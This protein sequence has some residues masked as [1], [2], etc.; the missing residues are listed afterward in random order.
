M[1][2]RS[3]LKA[4]VA[5]G[6]LLL[7]APAGA[8]AG[9]L[10]PTAEFSTSR[11][12]RLFP[13][14]RL[15][16]ADMHNH[17][18]LSD[19]NGDAAKAFASMRDA[20]LDVAALTDHAGTSWGAP[21]D[22]CMGQ[23]DCRSV[24]GIDE[25]AWART[26]ELANSA[27]APDAFTAIRGFEWS[28]PFLGHVNVWF[29]ERWIDPLHTGGVGPEGIGEHFHE[30]IPGAGPAVGPHVDAATRA[31]PANSGMALFYDWLNAAPTR[32]GIGGGAD[33]LT[34]FNHP[35]R[36]YG[37]FGY[38]RLDP[39]IRD[40]MVSMEVFNRGEDYLFAQYANGQPS[41][42]AECLDAGWRTGL[43][44]VTDEHGTNWGYP[45]GKGRSG[46]WVNELSRE[47][48]R[49]ALAARRFFATTLRG[50]RVDAGARSGAGAGG[51][52]EARMG[53]TLKHKKG[54]VTFA[55]DVDRGP[56]WWGKPLQVQVLRSGGR[57]PKVAHVED[58]TVRSDSEDV[59]TFTVNLDVADG[60]WVVLRVADPAGSNRE[61]G[62]AGH[63]GNAQ[64]IAYASPFWLQ[65]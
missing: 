63:P 50:L 46:L 54:P 7:G 36:E 43:L 60:S 52:L 29:S 6:A 17:T 15:A 47:G 31:N 62:P 16:H 21:A 40:R 11:A 1:H 23:K 55:L 51:P 2:R 38:F 12:S 59:L 13:G 8:L 30:N 53:S 10:G 48:V 41:P 42:L 61:P 18:L 49:E 33:A 37:R 28:S 27:D 5:G 32:P 39:R 19:G 26:R 9:S 45:D 4:A 65:P 22:P 14:T 25:A 24:A 57:V 56:D 35:G 58:F 44:G 64:G 3:L 34:G 20:G